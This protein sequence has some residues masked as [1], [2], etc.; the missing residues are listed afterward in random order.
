ML[1]TQMMMTTGGAN[2]ALAIMASMH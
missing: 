2:A 1:A